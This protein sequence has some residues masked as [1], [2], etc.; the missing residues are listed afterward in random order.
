MSYLN[1]LLVH[2]GTKYLA[3]GTLKEA[4][5]VTIKIGQ[6]LRAKSSEMKVIL[7]G[8]LPHD[9]KKSA[10]LSKVAKKNFHLTKFRKD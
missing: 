3:Y 2:Y 5:N 8:L 7:L 10:Q 4:V 1:Y 6:T 9:L